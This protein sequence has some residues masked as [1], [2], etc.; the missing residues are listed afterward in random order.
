MG[1]SE[2]LGAV[3]FGKIKE[4]DSGPPERLPWLFVNGLGVDVAAVPT[5]EVTAKGAV[6]LAGMSGP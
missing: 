2:A 6:P 1:R 4:E 3:P 5:G